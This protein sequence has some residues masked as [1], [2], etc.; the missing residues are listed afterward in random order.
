MKLSI[1]DYAIVDEGKSSI[2]AIEESVELARL[3][4]RLGYS[5]FWMAEHHQVPALASSSP[6]LLMLHLLQNTEKIQIGSG[7]IMIPH[8]SPYKISEWIKLLSALY[9]NRVNL[10]IGNNPGTRVVQKLM[11]T[12]PITRE[13]YNKSCKELVDILTGTGTF[14]QPP[15]AKVSQ[16]WLLST[17]EKSANLAAELGQNYVYG[18]FFNQAVDYIE[19][20][21]RCLQTYRTKMLEQDKKPQDVLA[22]FIAIGE[23]E[24]ETKDLVRSL[25]VWLLGKKEFTEFDRFP[26]I[27]TAKEYEIAES[28]IEKVEKNRTRLV[29]GTKDVVVEKL[30]KLATELE[31]E[32]L[33]C[34]PLVPTIEK[35][36]SII[37]ILAKELMTKEEKK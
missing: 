4:E 5:R 15:E 22:V 28:D 30:R 11:N 16:I 12:T 6:E 14:V 19:T 35:R 32:E 33:M 7:G 25:D 36:K 24:Q 13:E 20:A 3:A 9:P 1:L 18:L 29:W 37:E 27:S 17:S 23:D 2:E 10:G 21:K 8:Y 34:I 26:S 31:L